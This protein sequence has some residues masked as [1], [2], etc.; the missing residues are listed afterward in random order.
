MSNTLPNIQENSHELLSNIQSLQLVEQDLVNSLDS[1]PNMTSAQQALIIEKI[2]N[3]SKMRI[4]LYNTLG[5]VNTFFQDALKNSSGT[6][7]EQTAAIELIENDLNQAKQKL[8]TL[9]DDKNNKIRLIEINTYY[10]QKYMEHTQL[11]KLVIVML[12]LIII[13]TILSKKGIISTRMY[14]GLVAAVVAIGIIFFLVKRWVSIFMRDNMNYQKY[15]WYFN[16][17]DA[18]KPPTTE[19]TDPWLTVGPYGTCIGSSCCY[20]GQTYDESIN[21]CVTNTSDTTSTATATT[22]DN[23]SSTSQVEPNISESFLTY[24]DFTGN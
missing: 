15:D 4:N 1:N 5:G 2:N 7:K 23:V 19:S 12:V 20:T 3:I 17:A 13:L 24:G 22:A 21:K 8:T 16:A 10:G 6:L 18:P 9:E 11:M 14:S